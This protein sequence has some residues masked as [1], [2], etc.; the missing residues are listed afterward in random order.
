MQ[1]LNIISTKNK[2]KITQ[3]HTGPDLAYADG[4]MYKALCEVEDSIRGERVIVP[5]QE[6]QQICGHVLKLPG[7]ET[8]AEGMQTRLKISHL[9]Y[10]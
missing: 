6:S 8:Q 7:S 2:K 10:R 3:T 5:Q 9:I 4:V 1:C